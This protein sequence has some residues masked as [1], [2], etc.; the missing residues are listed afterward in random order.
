[1]ELGGP[2]EG[3]SARVRVARSGRA[4]PSVIAALVDDPKLAKDTDPGVRQ[5]AA[6]N[7]RTPG[8]AVALLADDPDSAVRDTVAAHPA[9]PDMLRKKIVT[10]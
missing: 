4:S 1:M 6:S 8:H 3:L 9:M 10:A 7:P 5:A 2:P